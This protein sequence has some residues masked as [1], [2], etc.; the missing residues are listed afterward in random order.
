MLLLAAMDSKDPM[1]SMWI[2]VAMVGRRVRN[3]V[4]VETTSLLESAIDRNVADRR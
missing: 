4:V 3:D 2:V 1:A